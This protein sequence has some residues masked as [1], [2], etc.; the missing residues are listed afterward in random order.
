MVKVFA[1]LAKDAPAALISVEQVIPEVSE[2]VIP[3]VKEVSSTELVSDTKMAASTRGSG[4][5]SVD[6][7]DG[8]G[9]AF[10]PG[11]DYGFGDFWNEYL[12]PGRES[13]SAAAQQGYKK[14]LAN[15]EKLYGETATA[16]EY[17]KFIQ[18][19]D[20]KYAPG[21][22]SKF[23]PSVGTALAG[24]LASD[25]ILGTNII[26]PPEEEKIDLAAMQNQGA[27]LLASDSGTY[28]IDDSYLGSNPYYDQNIPPTQ[29]YPPADSFVSIPDFNIAS[30]V[31]PPV[32]T[33]IQTVGNQYA[34]NQYAGNQYAGMLGG[35]YFEQT[36]YD[37]SN[38]QLPVMFAATGGEIMG[39]GTPTSDSV[40]AMLSDGEFVMNARAVRGAGGGDRQQ[41]AK[42]MYEMMR[43][44]ERT[45]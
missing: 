35:N 45:A 19:L 21:M 42:R 39:P 12:S 44:F 10:K 33:G 2:K 31:N 22:L 9:K 25:T 32:A 14:D 41:G 26:T 4:G 6:F 15:F 5:Q 8:L 17:T 40:P 3:E 16:G 24:G 28:G 29:T 30:S 7:K 27:D 36:P 13:V 38:Y 43:S 23:G 37:N 34:G 1:S 11:D 18:G 20:K